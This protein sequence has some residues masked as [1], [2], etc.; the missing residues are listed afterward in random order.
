MNSYLSAFI[1]NIPTK[2]LKFTFLENIT[3]RKNTGCY[4]L[5]QYL[6]TLADYSVNVKKYQQ[7]FLVPLPGNGCRI[8]FESSSSSY[9]FKTKKKTF[10]FSLV[11]PSSLLPIQVSYL[12]AFLISTSTPTTLGRLS[13]YTP[14][15]LLDESLEPSS[16]DLVPHQATRFTLMPHRS[17]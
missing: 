13:L 5:Q 10:S 3:F 8:D 15:A 2:I 1:Y 12:F 16:L 11:L 14:S 9:I 4:M 6:R 17:N 7:V